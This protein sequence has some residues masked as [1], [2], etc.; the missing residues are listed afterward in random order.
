MPSLQL[1]SAA[2][3]LPALTHC[4]EKNQSSLEL[5]L[6]PLAGSVG[7][8]KAAAPRTMKGVLRTGSPSGCMAVV[9]NL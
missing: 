8:L 3:C 5:P 1:L 4:M 9:P 6:V 7:E 2:V